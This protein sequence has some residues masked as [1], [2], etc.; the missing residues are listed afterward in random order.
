[1]E[2]G[3][4][5]GDNKITTALTNEGTPAARREGRTGLQGTLIEAGNGPSEKTDCDATNL[6]IECPIRCLRF[7][8]LLSYE[9]GLD[10]TRAKAGVCLRLVTHRAFLSF[11]LHRAG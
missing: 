3:F 8:I 2:F 4:P 7:H 6:R 5:K 10:Y 9:S 11:P 1:M